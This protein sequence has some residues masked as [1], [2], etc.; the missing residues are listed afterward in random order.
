MRGTAGILL[1]NEL[2]P[3]DVRFDTRSHIDSKTFKEK[4]KKFAKKYPKLYAE[5]ISKIANLGEK[6][7]FYLGSN[8]G[9]NDLKIDEKKRK[10]IISKIEKGIN[11]AKTDDEKRAILLKGLNYATEGAIKYAGN[12]NEMIQQVKSGSR[13][14]PVQFARMSVGPVYAV[15]MNQ[16]PKPNLIKSSFTGGL[17]AQEYFNVAS[18]GR[19]SSVQAANATSEPGALGKILIANT[20]AQKITMVDCHTKNGVTMSVDD[21]H[22]LGRFEAGTDKLIDE[23][24]VRRL[25]AAGKKTIKVRS[26][27][28]CQAPKGVCAK[29]YGLLP[30]GKLPSVGDNVGIKAAQ[31]IGEILTQMTLSTKHSTMGKQQESKLTGVDG[32]KTITNSPSSFSGAAV[33]AIEPGIVSR[34]VDAPQGGHYIYVGNRKY[35]AKPKMKVLVKAGESVYKG[36]KLT[37]GIVTPKQV[38]ETRG[39]GKAREHEAEMLHTLFKDSTGKDLQ[40]KHFE[41]LAR[42]HLSLGQNKIAEIDELSSLMDGYP[43]HKMKS[44]VGDML[45]G[46]Y[47]AEDVETI[48]KGTKI[49]S[50][51]IKE[52]KSKNYSSVYVTDEAPAVKP[53]FKSMEQ[54]PSFTGNLFSKMNYRHITKAIKDEILYNKKPNIISDYPSDRAMHTA[55]ML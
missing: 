37:D 5:R 3:P 46:K 18:Q 12:T 16:L 28:T 6:M 31:T 17:N 38:L 49:D 50:Q 52:L 32:F 20:D 27:I 11:K 53:I 51:V 44:P 26:P 1:I 8:V 15:D 48:S 47:I 2:L 14:K 34:I 36:Q 19:Y 23:A 30:N 29:C 55:G 40:K 54:K 4:M 45:I 35:T 42:G 22:I 33:V 9:P 13:G 25:K 39:V 10:S 24:Y 43:K 41:L 7:T 21:P